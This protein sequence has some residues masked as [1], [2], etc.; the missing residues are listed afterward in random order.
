LDVIKTRV[1][2]R[3]YA[4]PQSGFLV[5]KNLLAE[6]GAGALFKGLIPK[7]GVVGPKLVFSFT[8]AQH[9][10]AYLEK[11]FLRNWQE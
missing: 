6:E 3:S 8:I 11:H 9:L 5:I 10:I 4:N 1:Q 2:S 7:L